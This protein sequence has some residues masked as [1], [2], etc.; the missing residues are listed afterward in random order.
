MDVLQ[1]QCFPEE[2]DPIF[3]HATK[4]RVS[5]K[6]K[7]EE[8]W[9]YIDRNQRLQLKD[10]IYDIICGKR[11]TLFG[12]VIEKTSSSFGDADPY[13]V[14]FE[15]LVSRFDMY[16]SRINRI[17]QADGREE[18][19]GLIVIAESSYEKTIGLLG[20]RLREKGTRW[21]LLHN[22]SDVPLFAPSKDTRLLQYADFCSNAIYGKYSKG[23]S[24]DF[25]K[26]A[27]KF[28]Q[29]NGTVHGLSHKTINQNCFCPACMCR[30]NRLI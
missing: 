8:P 21:G 26:I 19:R 3:F 12:C 9:C 27:F 15:D 25:D 24:K 11:G 7:L 22:V 28:D 10:K 23:L 14:A 20:R 30:K 13:E 16:L 6:D 5:D 29:Y 18:Q 4:L 17:L 2:K 1:R